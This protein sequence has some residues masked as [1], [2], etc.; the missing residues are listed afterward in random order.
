MNVEEKNEPVITDF[1]KAKIAYSIAFLAAIFTISKFFNFEVN[2]EDLVQFLKVSPR[3]VLYPSF[4]FLNIFFP[5]V[6]LLFLSVYCF[7]LRFVINEEN[8]L[9][10]VFLAAGNLFFTLAFLYLPIYFSFLLIGLVATSLSEMC[11]SFLRSYYLNIYYVCETIFQ[12]KDNL[13]CVYSILPPFIEFLNP[14]KICE[15]LLKIIILIIGIKFALR[16]SQ[17]F[18]IR[19]K[20]EKQ[21][22]KERNEEAKLLNIS[23][24]IDFGLY[25]EAIKESHAIIKDSIINIYTLIN[26]NKVDPIKNLDLIDIANKLEFNYEEINQDINL[27]QKLFKSVN[28]NEKLTEDAAKKSYEI[29]SKIIHL[30]N[31]ENICKFLLALSLKPIKNG[32]YDKAINILEKA[33]KIANEFLMPSN[34]YHFML[35]EAIASVYLRQEKYD[36]AEKEFR[37]LVSL[38]EKYYGKNHKSLS[39]SLNHLAQVLQKRSKFKLAEKLVKRALNIS[40]KAYGKKSKVTAADLN[41]LGSLYQTI[42]DINNAKKVYLEVLKIDK[43]EYGNE[44]AQVANDLNNL[45]TIYDVKGSYE[46]AEKCF[47]KAIEIRERLTGEDYFG[48]SAPLGNLANV[49]LKLAKHSKAKE[50]LEKG[51]KLDKENFG[52]N[53][54]KVTFGL[55]SLASLYKKEADYEVELSKKRELYAN[56]EKLLKESLVIYEKNFGS[57]S[58][59]TLVPIANLGEFYLRINDVVNAKQYIE[60]A[61]KL[62]ESLFANKPHPEH[63]II[64]ANLADVYAREGE[65]NKAE[66][67]NKYVIGV[68]KSFYKSEKHENI[69]TAYNNLAMIYK[70]KKEYNNAKKSFGKALQIME[71]SLGKE[72][73]DVASICNNIRDFYEEIGDKDKAKFFDERAKSIFV[74]YTKT[75]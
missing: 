35:K 3:K 70:Q 58:H 16:T 8:I 66:K 38:S 25:N 42:G 75:K 34:E 11:A 62:I 54:E 6:A 74:K 14:I 10:K 9:S 1:A 61:K 52:N 17:V 28:N 45:G 22:R 46:K 19:E 37:E 32:E 40:K 44:S 36:E 41:A 57:E 31:L 2:A 27:I 12:D 29:T 13:F 51:L 43:K 59:K 7:G 26:N 68:F 60:K 23:K 53:S 55:N 5:N 33:L 72:H 4:T 18:N 49:Y 15:L 56:A 21:E 64:Y 20:E 65:Y 71:S 73:M 48:I 24:L 67:I 69:A 63:M 30:N 47:E 50:L 39:L